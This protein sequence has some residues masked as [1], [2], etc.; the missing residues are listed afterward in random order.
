MQ[1]EKFSKYKRF[2]N[3][4]TSRD[5]LF[6]IECIL[7]KRAS[8]VES[9]KQIALLYSGRSYLCVESA[10]TLF[11]DLGLIVGSSDYFECSEFF[12]EWSGLD[13][14]ALIESFSIRLIEFYVEK[15]IV[16]IQEIKYIRTSDTFLLPL[17]SIRI[18]YSC[19]R[20]LLQSFGLIE[21]SGTSYILKGY[22]VKFLSTRSGKKKKLS[23]SRL[24]SLLEKEK[25]QGEA[26]ELFVLNYEKNRLKL[27]ERKDNIKRISTYDVTAGFDI[28]SYT[29]I[30][31]LSLDRFI[32]VKTYK[33]DTH[34]FWSKN[35][36]ET[37]KVLKEKYYVYLVDYN[38]INQ[39]GYTPLIIKDPYKEIFENQEHWKLQAESY[40]VSP[41]ALSVSSEQDYVLYNMAAEETS[42]YG[43]KTNKRHDESLN[44]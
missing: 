1:E 11:L 37:A 14:N 35:E 13:D 41:C 42:K 19:L 31:S 2:L 24:Q 34:F 22:F 18:K 36:I 17:N 12:K 5:I 26:G 25:E 28:V 29:N 44:Q 7:S 43:S 3:I 9:L 4:G 30:F 10:I 20:N 23:E 8:S 33:G 6:A 40:K 21:R 39:D 15:E 16:N 32:E 38:R 27:H